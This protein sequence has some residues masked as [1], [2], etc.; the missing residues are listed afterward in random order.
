MR[1]NGAAAPRLTGVP[2]Q[3]ADL[4]LTPRDPAPERADERYRGHKRIAARY[5]KQF[6]G[7]LIHTPGRGW[8]MWTG[9][10]WRECSDH[11]PWNA[12][13]E[14]CRQAIRDSSFMDKADRKKLLSV[15]DKCETAA[16]TRSVLEHARRWPGIGVDD[17]ELDARAD[18]FAVENGVLQ[19]A[20]GRV[21]FLPA[22]P[23]HLLT[24]HGGVSYDPEADSPTY[25]RMLGLYQPDVDVRDYL[26]RL[27]GA[28]M[29]GAQNLQHLI[30]WY[31]ETAGN[32]KGTVERTI[33]RVFGT[34]ARQLPVEALASKGKFDQYRDE[35]AKLKGARLVFAS[36]PSERMRFDVGTVKRI[37]GGDP[38]TA[39]EVYKGSVTFD[40]TWLIMMSTNERVGMPSDPG[41]QRRI[42]EIPWEYVIPRDQMN[43]GVED[44]LAAEGSGIL[45]HLVRGWINFSGGG[46][47]HP[48]S[49][50]KAT[51]DYFRSVDPIQRFVSEALEPGDGTDTITKDR[52]YQLYTTWC[53]ESGERF[54]ET[55]RAFG[56]KLAK[57]EPQGPG[58]TE[59]RTASYRYWRGVTINP[60]YTMDPQFGRHGHK[61]GV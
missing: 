30:T 4:I 61:E 34:Y 14:V 5:A 27:F 41:M 13:E 3:P 33:S 17:V 59:G 28:A 40:P 16:G 22:D 11:A 50:E 20:A 44:Q 46:I 57:P 51:L 19:L 54:V 45:N 37:T 18:L 35:K 29:E 56:L 24:K 2:T 58:L 36:E 25:D 6:A 10:Y 1:T 60:D 7:K 31:G 53:S 52:M 38:I 26:H 48:E 49:V 43:P 47:A 55:K 8:L 15:V 32:G 42:K 39:R 23:R 21:D 12:V 9:A